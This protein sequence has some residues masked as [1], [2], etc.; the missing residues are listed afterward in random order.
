MKTRI[1]KANIIKRFGVE[2]SLWTDIVASN[3]SER[4][5]LTSEVRFDKK[6]KARWYHFIEDF[7]TYREAETLA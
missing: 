3:G 6:N 5:H 4:Y 2:A 7:S 1:S